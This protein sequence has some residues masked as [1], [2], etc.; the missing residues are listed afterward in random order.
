M[1]ALESTHA[2][3]RYREIVKTS[4]RWVIK[5]GSSLVTNQG[6]G[7]DGERIA[8]WVEQIA[9]LRDRGVAEIVLVSSG[10]VAA[11]MSRLGWPQRPTEIYRLQAAAAV[12]QMILIQAYE[13]HFQ[14]FGLHA[15]QVLLTQ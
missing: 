5:V 10:A 9:A 11:G 7:L 1:T 12:G 6:Q 2:T 3:E 4:R 14:R 13:S 15:A 8:N